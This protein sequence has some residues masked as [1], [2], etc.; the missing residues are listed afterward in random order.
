MLSTKFGYGRPAALAEALVEAFFVG[1]NLVDFF[2]GFGVSQTGVVVDF[3]F[4][5]DGFPFIIV[6]CLR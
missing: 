6:V 4:P 3:I 2:L 1:V 5:Y